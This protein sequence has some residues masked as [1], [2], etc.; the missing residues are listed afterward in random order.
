MLMNC[1]KLWA[2]MIPLAVQSPTISQAECV[3]CQQ[4]GGAGCA[5]LLTKDVAVSLMSSTS[6]EH[7]LSNSV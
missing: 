6:A 3:W 4:V 7:I 1:I 5:V 2:Q